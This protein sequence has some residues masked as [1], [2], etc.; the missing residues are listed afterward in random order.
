MR[1][2]TFAAVACG[3]VLAAG[4]TRADDAPKGKA[5]EVKRIPKL[6][7]AFL[8]GLVGS[9]DVSM[10]G[11]GA[12]GT[13]VSRARKA[14]DDTTL[15]WETR[16]TVMG[17]PFYAV[18]TM[19]VDETGKGARIV[20]F[21]MTSGADAVAY[22]GSVA[23][24]R[25]E[26]SADTGMTW[27]LSKKA[28]AYV[29]VVARGG[30]T[31]FTS[32]YSKAAK[33]VE[34]DAPTAPKDGF[35]PPVIGTWDAKGEWVMAPEPIQVAGPSVF[36]WTLGGSMLLHEYDRTTSKGPTHALGLAR[37]TTRGT[38]RLWWF[39]TEHLDPMPAEGPLTDAAWHGKGTFPDGQAIGLEW[40][41]TA[42]GYEMRYEMAGATAGHETFTRKK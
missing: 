36:R 25:V 21:D 38:L 13:G 14:C 4:T 11:F 33:E 27:T 39:D 15:L 42:D 5:P 30:Q 34:I 16:M 35:L 29:A 31:M 22:R 32:T 6:E 40:S 23:D 10:D 12:T 41:K 7:N 28:D 24:D 18:T 19:R 37:W 8:S 9:W 26:A 3:I 1:R 20:R 17:R 2:W